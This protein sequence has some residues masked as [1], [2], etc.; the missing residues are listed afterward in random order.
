MKI[1]PTAKLLVF[2]IETSGLDANRGHIICAAAK[3]VGQKDVITW[4]IDATPK[5]GTTPRSFFDDS[6]I[7]KGLIPLMEE[8][9]VVIGHYASRFDVPYVTTRAIANGVAP[10]GPV[11]VVDTWSAARS[12]LKLARNDLGSVG[13]L[14]RVKHQ[15]GHI[16]WPEWEVA[17]Y[18]DTKAISKLL[19]YNV[20][21]VRSTEEVYLK[22]RPIIKHH[23]Y[24][25]YP[26]AG[27]AR[28]PACGN[29]TY[30][31]RGA[32]RTRHFEIFRGC[33]KSCGTWFELGR[34]KIQ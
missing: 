15:K 26:A 31:S 7:V 16:P 17:R 4:R 34:K 20:Q 12:G 1:N 24:V 9:D 3:W 5:Y 14:F 29:K 28:C 21:D 6:L 32:R 33:C 2:D 11:T 18:G 30:Q 25:G 13:T 22:L 10:P 27:F 23:P 19:A 8:A